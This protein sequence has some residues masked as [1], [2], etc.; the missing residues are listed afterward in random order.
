MP[1][2]NL[3]DARD[4]YKEMRKL[5][6]KQQSLWPTEQLRF[7]LRVFCEYAARLVSDL[8]C[9]SHLATVAEYAAVHWS[10]NTERKWQASG[11]SPTQFLREQVLR[12]LDAYAARLDALESAAARGES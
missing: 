2:R 11:L 6:V 10:H 9:E 4:H 3:R 8:V 7:V 12:E 1:S 5:L